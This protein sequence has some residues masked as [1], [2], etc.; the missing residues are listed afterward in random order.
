MSCIDKSNNSIICWGGKVINQ[1]FILQL[2][3]FEVLK[4]M[5]VGIDHICYIYIDV[6]DDELA[7][8]VKC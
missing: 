4:I 3:D 1:Q 7:N 2:H 8:K 6:D 5:S